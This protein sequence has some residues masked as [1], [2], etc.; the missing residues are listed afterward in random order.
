MTTLIPLDAITDSPYQTRRS[1]DEAA[2]RELADS[3]AQHPA[4]GRT[5]LTFARK[6]WPNRPWY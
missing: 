3:I 4:R 2:I 5:R 1:Y 6:H